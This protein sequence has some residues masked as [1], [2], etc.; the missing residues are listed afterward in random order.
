M[1]F[2]KFIKIMKLISIFFFS[3]FLLA[4]QPTP[5]EEIVISKENLDEKLLITSAPVNTEFDNM[6]SEI[7][8]NTTV[9][10]EHDILGKTELT[11]RVDSKIQPSLV[12]QIMFVKPSVFNINFVD[13]ALDYFFDDIYYDHILTT[14]DWQTKILYLKQ[15]ESE[16]NAD[17]EY[18]DETVEYFK[19]L[20]ANAPQT[21]LN[22]HKNFQS[23]ESGEYLLYKNYPN[24]SGIGFLSVINRGKS[25]TLFDYHIDFYNKE[26]VETNLLYEGTS[27]RGMSMTYSEASKIAEQAVK[28][29][30]DDNMCLLYS[31]YVNIVELSDFS[32]DRIS[33]IKYSQEC[34][35]C[36]EFYFV[37]K[38]NTINGAK[39]NLASRYI[40]SIDYNFAEIWQGEEI[41]IIVDDSGIVSFLWYSPTEVLEN[42][43]YNAATMD[44]EEIFEIFK[45][46]IIYNYIWAEDKDQKIEIIIDDIEYGIVR[47]PDKNNINTYITIPVWYFNGSKVINT[48]YYTENTTPTGKERNTFIIISAIDGT[49]IDANLGY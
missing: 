48:D 14:E 41:K 40:E 49:I 24:E 27:A 15:A 25:C 38:Y 13:K 22:A 9:I 12:T 18:I 32:P 2:N 3:Y 31:T 17:K 28:I 10:K 21:N 46:N 23:D 43:N 1:S 33:N 29:L 39:F 36:Y 34:N 8:W 20:E 7:K 47:L 16:E 5:E 45:K 4:C 19:S 35:Q 37:R 30:C 44:F 6:I 42:I 11:V 26:L